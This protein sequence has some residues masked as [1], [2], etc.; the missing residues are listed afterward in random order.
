MKEELYKKL[1]AKIT[2][3]HNCVESHN[4]VWE[5]QHR[6]DIVMLTENHM[7]SG[8]GIDAGTSFDFNKSKADKLVFNSSYHTMDEYGY[9]GRWIE[10]TVTVTP[11]LQHRYNLNIKGNF[12]KDHDIKDYLYETFGWAL[13]TIV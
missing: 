12:G 4:A 7:P 3:Y 13:D 9:Y 6:N 11:S 1:A 10:F 5:D 2:A 8:S